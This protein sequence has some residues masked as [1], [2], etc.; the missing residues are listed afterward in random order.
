[1]AE[2]KNARKKAR[3][4]HARI[5]RARSR[6]RQVVAGALAVALVA[7]LAAT[8]LGIRFLQVREREGLVYV[9]L[10]LEGFSEPAATA[11]AEILRAEI[12]ADAGTP[13]DRDGT[14][15]RLFEPDDP[16]RHAPQ[17]DVI[18][19]PGGAAIAWD[20]YI[21]AL[22][23]RRIALPPG[24]TLDQLEAALETG[25]APAGSRATPP[26][27]VAGD[28]RRDFTAFTA[29]L[30][31]ELLPE[32]GVEDLRTTT[33]AAPAADAAEAER[34]LATLDP[35]AETVTAWTDAAVLAGN[36][37]NVDRVGLGRAVTEGDGDAFFVP[38]SFVKQLAFSDAFNLRITPLPV[39]PGRRSGQAVG[40]MIGVSPGAG[41]RRAAHVAVRDR[42]IAGD[43][44]R[45]IET[46]TAWSPVVLDGPPVNAA[47]RAVV[48]MFA[49]TARRTDLS[50]WNGESALI[51]RFHRRLR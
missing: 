48:R 46:A 10:Q 5:A 31:G 49:V 29:Y 32:A 44:Q 41:P 28:H 23:R 30:A 9:E 25:R 11:L 24:A 27:V 36:W 22:D 35:V 26:L 14:V 42:L 3:R 45:E 1:M 37:T 33:V 15:L 50:R 21:L 51:E 19:G 16:P 13:S 17:P 43:V 6:R 38:R 34:L 7:G 40:T 2:T 20:P 18:V 39:A 4:E 47:H 12:A 8:F